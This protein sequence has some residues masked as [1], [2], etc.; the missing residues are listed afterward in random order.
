MRQD[1]FNQ[2]EHAAA[3]EGA[4]R[5]RSAA[6]RAVSE[7]VS[8]ALLAL[9]AI[10]VGGFVVAMLVNNLVQQQG[11]LQEE[12]VRNIYATRQAIGI[13]LARVDNT[14]RVEVVIATGDT[15][16]PIQAVYINGTPAD[17]NITLTN[18]DTVAYGAPIPPYTAAVI[19]CT[20]PSGAG[21]HVV[22][23]VYPGGA[24]TAL[25]E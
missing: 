10:T 6:L 9:I 16:T 5:G 20:P 7:L 13:V 18:G 23:I 4:A 2:V 11:R 14:G 19:R 15:P 24:V 8:A 17:C 3:Q 12:I 25:A 21:P 1:T 22:R